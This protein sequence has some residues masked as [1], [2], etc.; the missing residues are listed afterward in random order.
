MTPAIVSF[1]FCLLHKTSLRSNCQIQNRRPDNC[2][3]VFKGTIL[4][5][6]LIFWRF[7]KDK[8][9]LLEITRIVLANTM[10]L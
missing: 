7:S 9:F 4:R 1:A 2:V 3:I 10:E 6:H 8:A 5:L